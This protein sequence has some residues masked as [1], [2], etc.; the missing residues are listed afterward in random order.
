ME[1]HSPALASGASLCP[2]EPKE[3]VEAGLFSSPTQ[4]SCLPS[5]A[6]SEKTAM[7]KKRFAHCSSLFLVVCFA[8]P[9]SCRLLHRRL[10][11]SVLQR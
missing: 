10:V 2:A 8:A 1:S 9:W 5:P 7:T 3:S 4:A 11:F 6:V